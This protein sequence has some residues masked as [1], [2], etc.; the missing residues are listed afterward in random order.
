MRNANIVI[1][2]KL[3]SAPLIKINVPAKEIGIPS[4]TQKASLI[5]KNKLNKIMS[6]KLKDFDVIDVIGPSDVSQRGGVFSFN[7]EGWDPT[8]I[9]MHLDEEYNIAIRSGMHCVHSWFNSRGI[10]GTARASAYLYNN[11]SDVLSFTSAIE[12]MLT[13]NG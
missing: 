2:F 6:D 1:I 3:T 4:I 10:D 5:S 7:I 11:E 12:E 9:A 13:K 8:E